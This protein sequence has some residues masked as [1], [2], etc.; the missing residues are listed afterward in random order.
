M[1]SMVTAP[2]P[3]FIAQRKSTAGTTVDV[4]YQELVLSPCTYSGYAILSTAS[5]VRGEARSLSLVQKEF[6]SGII[7]SKMVR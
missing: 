3:R 4:L 1:R 5:R 7:L 2:L 6:V